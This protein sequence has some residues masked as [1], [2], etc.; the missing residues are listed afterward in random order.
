MGVYSTGNSYGVPED[1]IYSFPVSIKVCPETL[2]KSMPEIYSLISTP[3]PEIKFIFTSVHHNRKVGF[4][5]TIATIL[6]FFRTRPGRLLMGWPSM[7]SQEPRWM[8]QQLN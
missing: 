2:L 7:T 5:A 6:F 8:Q 4:L 1:L 3:N